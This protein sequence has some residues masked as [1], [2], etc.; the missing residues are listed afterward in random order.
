MGCHPSRT[1]PLYNAAAVGSI[2]ASLRWRCRRAQLNP[3]TNRIH[4]SS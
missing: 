2:P 3:W 1:R 4:T